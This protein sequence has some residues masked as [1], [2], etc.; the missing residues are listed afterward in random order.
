MLGYHP[1]KMQ[2]IVHGQ[3][4]NAFGHGSYYEGLTSAVSHYGTRPVY[5]GSVR[6]LSVKLK[7]P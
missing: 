4:R 6:I 1:M 5:S 2:K 3:G 7:D